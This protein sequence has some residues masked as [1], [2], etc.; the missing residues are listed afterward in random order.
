MPETSGGSGL[1]ES[2][3]RDNE[4]DRNDAVRLNCSERMLSAGPESGAGGQVD[5]GVIG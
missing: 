5:P 1:S 2:R 4:Q 3:R